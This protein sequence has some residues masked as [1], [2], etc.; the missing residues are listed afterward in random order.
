MYD[1]QKSIKG[2]S[3]DVRN[4]LPVTTDFH[5]GGY[6]PDF[7]FFQDPRIEDIFKKAGGR[8]QRK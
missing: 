5:L 8:L 4:K 6:P 3:R 7:P 1:G 2:G